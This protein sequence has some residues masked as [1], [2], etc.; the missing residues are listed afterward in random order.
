M[1][2]KVDTLPKRGVYTQYTLLDGFPLSAPGVSR[3]VE[4]INIRINIRIYMYSLFRY[5]YM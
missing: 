3:L 1:W 5:T 2:Y 4:Y